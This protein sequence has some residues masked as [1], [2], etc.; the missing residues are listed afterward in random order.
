[1]KIEET[2]SLKR[3]QGGVEGVTF[4]GVQVHRRNLLEPV[5]NNRRNAKTDQHWS[6]YFSMEN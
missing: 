1:M 4:F 6:D 5:G 3:D 2:F